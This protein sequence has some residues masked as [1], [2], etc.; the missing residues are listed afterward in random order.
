MTRRQDDRRLPDTPLDCGHRFL[1][2]PSSCRPG[3]LRTPSAFEIRWRNTTGLDPEADTDDDGLTDWAETFLWGTDPNHADTDGDGTADNVELMMGADPFD[4]DEDGDGV[5]DGTDEEDWLDNP[6][7]A[8]N[9]TNDA[10]VVVSLNEAVPQGSSATL[11][12]GDLAIPLRLVSGAPRRGS[13]RGV[14]RES[15]AGGASTCYDDRDGIPSS[16]P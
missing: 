16:C 14:R 15:I 3:V 7:W 6:L 12:L 1:V 5:P 13:R 8:A 9:S 11:I 10:N 2:V 4:A